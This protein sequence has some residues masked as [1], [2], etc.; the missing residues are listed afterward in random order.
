MPFSAYLFT[1]LSLATASWLAA[2]LQAYPLQIAMLTS[3]IGLVRLDRTGHRRWFVLSLLG[4]AL[5][6]LFW[7]KAVLVLPTMLALDV[8][9]L[10]RGCRSGSAGGGSVVAAGSGRRPDAPRCLPGGPTSP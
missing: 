6:L 4:Q 7:E 9:V 5:G 8:L 10:S 2:G 3:L 1:P